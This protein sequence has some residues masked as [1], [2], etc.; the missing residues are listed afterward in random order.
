MKGQR[1]LTIGQLFAITPQA[2]PE[3]QYSAAWG[4]FTGRSGSR[5]RHVPLTTAD[6]RSNSTFGE[7]EQQKSVNIVELETRRARGGPDRAH[8]RRAS[9]C[10]MSA[11]RTRNSMPRR[12]R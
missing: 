11:E 3:V 9:V 4:T 10:A 8:S 2:L 6:P 1:Q 7:V 5:V 12:T